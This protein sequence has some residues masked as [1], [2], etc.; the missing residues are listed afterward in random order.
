MN[1]IISILKVAL[2]IGVNTVPSILNTFAPGMGT[3][4]STVISNVLTAE[5]KH[6][7]GQGAS[8]ASTA[9]E[10]TNAA[11][12]AIVQLIERQ[13]GKELADEALF[14]EGV[15]ELQEAVVKI[16]NAFRVLPK[17]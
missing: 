8:K 7:P 3:L 14:A 10:L 5:A 15:Q 13:T 9:L 1:K 2:C 16:G 6:G 17:A 11:I 4:L 12:P